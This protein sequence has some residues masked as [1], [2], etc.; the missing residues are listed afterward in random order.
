MNQKLQQLRTQ[1]EQQE[2][3][4]IALKETVNELKQLLQAMNPKPSGGAK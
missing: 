4:L 3:E 2:T 1:R